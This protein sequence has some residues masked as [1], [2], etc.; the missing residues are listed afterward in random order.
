MFKTVVY[1]WKSVN[2]TAPSYLSQLCVPVASASGR[3]RLSQP[4]WTYYKF[5][6]PELQPAGGASLLRDHLC[7]TVL[8]P[9][10]GDQRSLCTLSGDKSDVL[11]SG[12][13]KEHSPPPGAVVVFS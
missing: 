1:V 4:R 11:V 6:E 13:Q 3:Q 7:G 10:Y 8:L 9:L 2:G 12:E 5:A